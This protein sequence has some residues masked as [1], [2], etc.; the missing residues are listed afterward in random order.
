MLTRL[1]GIGLW[2]T[3]VCGPASVMA[4]DDRDAT[5]ARFSQ[6]VAPVLAAKCV[7]CHG[8]NTPKG[9]LDL[10]TREAMLRGGEDGPGLSPGRPDASPILRRTLSQD[11]QKPEMPEKGEP[12][13]AKEAE[14][15]SQWIA[16]GAPWPDKF[17][18]REPT[19]ADANWWSLQPIAAVEPPAGDDLPAAWAK[20]PIDRF[21]QARLRA[22]GLSPNPPAD[23][24]AFVR[25]ATFDLTGLP[26]TPA[27][28]A[29]FVR[30]CQDEAAGD[31]GAANGA[32]E[33]LINRLLDSPHYGERW[34]R[35]WLDVV[36]FGESRGYER[37]EI[38]TNLWP[39]RDYIIRSFNE[40]KPFDRFILEHLAGDVIGKDQPD[41]EI[42][43]AFLV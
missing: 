23:P 31:V 29:A 37:N 1:T 19:K 26:P 7:S 25:R 11:G 38:I 12:L 39:F 3:V 5:L 43:S 42:G 9:K 35:H 34:G 13:T 20:N 21:V 6:T 28:V 32:C 8:P 24:Q 27:E 15:L 22:K 33:R 16:A 10:T 18:L 17:V 41:I 40:D 30:E 36:R 14:A 2:L 4:D